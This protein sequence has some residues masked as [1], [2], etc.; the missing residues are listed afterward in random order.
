MYL[1]SSPP[2]ALSFSTLKG[3]ACR[4]LGQKNKK[5]LSL[6]KMVDFLDLGRFAVMNHE[7]LPMMN[8]ELLPPDI[9]D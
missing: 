5:L 4:A 7:R 9:T 6:I 8:H 2:S 1:T 3:E